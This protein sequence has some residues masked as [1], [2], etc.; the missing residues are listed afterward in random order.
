MNYLKNTYVDI[1]V[2][3]DLQLAVSA[4]I[5][6]L[7]FSRIFYNMGFLAKERL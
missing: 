1:S 2:F 7:C 3:V 5:Y 4:C 6:V